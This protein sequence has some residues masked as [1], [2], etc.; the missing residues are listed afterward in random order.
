M[1]IANS[2]QAQKLLRRIEV[3]VRRGC[4]EQALQRVPHLVLLDRGFYRSAIRPQL[5]H[6]LLLLLLQ[7]GLTALNYDEALLYLGGDAH[8]VVRCSPS[9]AQPQPC[10]VAGRVWMG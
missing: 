10:A 5:A 1:E 6:W 2:P 4:N 3:A 8:L 7:L 9:I